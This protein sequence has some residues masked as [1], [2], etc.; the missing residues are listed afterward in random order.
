M[1][2][3]TALKIVVA[4]YINSQENWGGGGGGIH[5]LNNNIQRGHRVT[6]SGKSTDRKAH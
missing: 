1:H 6:T 4:A 3:H 2:I 5:F